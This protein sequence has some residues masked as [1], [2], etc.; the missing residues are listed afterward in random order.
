RAGIALQT[1]F[2]RISMLFGPALA[3]IVAGAWGL[4]ICYLVDAVSFSAALYATIRLPSMRP[5]HQT[6]RGLEQGPRVRVVRGARPPTDSIRR[7]MR[8][9]LSSIVAG[10]AFIRDRPVIAAAFLTDLDAMLLGMPT[11]LFP[12][13]NAE[14]FGGRPQTL[15]L[16]TAAVGIGGLFS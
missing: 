10:L 12:A 6:G 8:P 5:G 3:G 14:H 1:L 13:L 16:L 9:D 15:G 7:A 4:R 11:S 2:G